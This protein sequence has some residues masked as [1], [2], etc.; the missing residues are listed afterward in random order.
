MK[1]TEKE[2]AVVNA[3]RQGAV[4]VANFYGRR[5]IDELDA[6][7]DIFKNV[8]SKKIWNYDLPQSDAVAF[9]KVMDNVEMTVYVYAQK[10]RP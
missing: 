6:K 8:E 9:T 5:S 2:K 3:M 1:L 10:N 7:M 4:I